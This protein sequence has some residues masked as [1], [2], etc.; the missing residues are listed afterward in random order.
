MRDVC[1][2]AGLWSDHSGSRWCR[3]KR[4][5]V[6][7]SQSAVGCLSSRPTDHMVCY[8]HNKRFALPMMA[9][10]IRKETISQRPSLSRGGYRLLDA[11]LLFIPGSWWWR[12]IYFQSLHR[13][14][15][16][17]Y[18]DQMCRTRSLASTSPQTLTCEIIR[19]MPLSLGSHC[20]WAACSCLLLTWLLQSEEHAGSSAH[21]SV[22]LGLY[23]AF[24]EYLFNEWMHIIHCR[25]F[26]TGL[27]F[28]WGIKSQLTYVCS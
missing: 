21:L 24:R 1:F 26:G 10:V 23:L 5:H 6:Q 2:N 13:H 12:N 28:H 11:L 15:W 16:H 9:I 20:S 4:S 22:G 25:S 7:V 8:I 14:F 27:V 17:F 18:F 3:D 19:S